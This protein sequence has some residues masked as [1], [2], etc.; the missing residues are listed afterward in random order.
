MPN[1][2]NNGPLETS[3]QEIDTALFILTAQVAAPMTLKTI[4]SKLTEEY[5]FRTTDSDLS[6]ARSV[7]IRSGFFQPVASTRYSTPKERRTLAERLKSLLIKEHKVDLTDG[8]FQGSINGEDK[9]WGRLLLE[10]PAP[11][12]DKPVD[13]GVIIH[14][15]L[16]YT[17]L[18]N[19]I[20]GAKSVRV[21]QTYMRDSGLF[22]D[23]AREAIKNGCKFEVLLLEPYSE[24]IRLRAKGL[25][26]IDR[27]DVDGLVVTNYKML[28]RLAKKYPRHFKF[29]TINELPSFTMLQLDSRIFVGFQWYQKLAQNGAYLEL[30]EDSENPMVED[31]N[32][33]FTELWKASERKD[34][35]VKFNCHFFRNGKKTERALSFNSENYDALFQGTHHK[36]DFHGSII[37]MLEGNS[38]LF[39]QTKLSDALESRREEEKRVGC[40]F[41]NI[42]RNRLKGVVIAVGIF[43]VEFEPGEIR[44]NTVLLENL[45]P[46]EVY[47]HNQRLSRKDKDN[48]I[49]E[50]LQQPDLVWN[51]APTEAI[52]SEK[53]S[54]WDQLETWLKRKKN[55]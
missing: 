36:I 8:Y 7:A 26:K 47:D 54:R 25:C 42:N 27:E 41:L 2:P 29:Q 30:N 12:E 15:G 40:F 18:Y 9:K 46:S 35:D 13:A 21:L 39:L 5:D 24:V 32:E 20:R 16:N 10:Y 4:A 23:N 14:D 38:C 17:N 37:E 44:I 31:I 52:F 55:L 1:L 3:I 6:K 33:H 45:N 34:Y 22:E 19:Q 28:S 43:V 53:I 51:N 50:F 49:R 11:E 48:L